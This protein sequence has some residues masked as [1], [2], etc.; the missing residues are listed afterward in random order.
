MRTFLFPFN[1]DYSPRFLGIFEYKTLLPFCIISFI[2]SLILSELHA[3]IMTGIYIFIL[4]ILPLFLLSNTTIHK[5]P[6]IHFLF[7]IVKHYISSKK[8][9]NENKND[10]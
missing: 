3:P 10:N 9:I 7:C 8:Y 2:I 4:G 1:F 6:L 5:E